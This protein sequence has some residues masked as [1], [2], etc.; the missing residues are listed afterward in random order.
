MNDPIKIISDFTSFTPTSEWIVKESGIPW[1]ELD[2]EIPKE[3]MFL[4]IDLL[5][6]DLIS[7]CSNVS[8][9]S[10]AYEARE[11]Y[12]QKHNTDKTD[13]KWK[14]ITLYGID[15]FII[16]DSFNYSDIKT[17]HYNWTN[18][19]D[20]CPVHKEFIDRNFNLG[21]DFYIKYAVLEP[22]GYTLPHCDCGCFSV[23]DS[24]YQPGSELYALTFMVKNAPGNIFNFYQFGDIPIREGKGF[25]LNVDYFHCTHNKSKENRYHMMIINTNRS[26]KTIL[27]V[28]KD[29]SIVQRSWK[30]SFANFRN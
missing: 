28:F 15:S 1:L 21:N 5:R 26:N 25:L 19:G 10:P 7:N 13:N 27:D 24:N 11:E 30:N 6:N 14:F 12:K 23:G 9:D 20:R 18:A 17:N 22:G 8:K 16:E 29:K 2:L 3:E 4:E